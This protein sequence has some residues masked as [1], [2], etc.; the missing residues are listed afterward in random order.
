MRQFLPAELALIM[1]NKGHLVGGVGKEKPANPEIQE[2]CDLVKHEFEV[3][4]GLNAAKFKAV[5]FKSQVVAGTI[6]FVK[7]DVGG[8]QFC[9]L[10]I[11]KP[12]PYTGEK[13]TLSDFQCGKKKDDPIGYF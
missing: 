5:S 9:H 7:V 12:L 10:R 8:D 6:Y 13:A 2:L 4:S 1:D 3:K 11:F